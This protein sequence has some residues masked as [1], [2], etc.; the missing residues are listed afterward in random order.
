MSG[1]AA[2]F[3]KQY[4][5]RASV[6]QL[7]TASGAQPWICS[8]YC[9]ADSSLNIY[10]LSLPDRRHS[11]ELAKN[12]QA[13]IAVAIKADQPVVG[14]QAEGRAEVVND[15]VIIKQIMQRYTEKHATGTDFYKNFIQGKNQHLLYRFVPKTFVLFDE[16]NFPGERQQVKHR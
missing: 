16:V 15:P 4:V 1:D 9:V 13:A 3:I 6:M 12:P 11:L 8:V 14:F 7:A 5:G 2:D 10:W